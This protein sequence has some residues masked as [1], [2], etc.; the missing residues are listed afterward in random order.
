MNKP[1][2]KAGEA[3]ATEEKPVTQY[4]TRDELEKGMTPEMVAEYENLFRAKGNKGEDE[5][6]AKYVKPAEEKPAEGE[7]ETP[8]AKEAREKAEQ[9]AKDKAA[10]EADKG[11]VGT[12]EDAQKLIKSMEQRIKG[13]EE[14]RL[15]EL[16]RQ[17][18]EARSVNAALESASVEARRK[19]EE[20]LKAP[21]PDELKLDDLGIKDDI[22]LL[23]PENQKKLLVTYNETLKRLSTSYGSVLKQL[24]E[25]RAATQEAL[26]TASAAKATADSRTD[27]EDEISAIDAMR[28]ENPQLFSTRGIKEIED[29]FHGFMRGLGDLIGYKGEA[30]K[31]GIWAKEIQDAYRLYFDKDK[32]KDLKAKADAE[33][34][35]LPKDFE[36]L[37]IVH[38]LKRIRNEN[39]TDVVVGKD[40]DGKEIHDHKPWDYRKALVFLDK[41]TRPAEN[42]KMDKA[43]EKREAEQRAEENRRRFAT[44]LPPDK[45]GNAVDASKIGTEEFT[46]RYEAYKMAKNPSVEDR[47]WLEAAMKAGGL[48]EA[49]IRAALIREEKTKKKG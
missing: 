5:F 25:T 49:E 46:D 22:D 43:R 23:E 14:G 42:P 20:L 47:Q 39:F 15:A 9:E 16:E 17:L 38:Q 29:E 7:G 35:A 11:E 1:D 19:A 3:V 37:Q 33:K 31:D 26:S 41:T 44:Q 32:G 36:D 28:R 40:K 10:A 27:T 45:G 13:M 21:L 8:E 48:T 4:S 12:L 30:C 24:K 34:L 18:Q 2:E 6:I